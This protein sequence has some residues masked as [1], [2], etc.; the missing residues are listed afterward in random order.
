[1]GLISVF[2][3]KLAVL[4]Q[5]QKYPLLQA[6]AGPESA[7]YAELARQIAGGN[8]G[9]GPGL[10]FFPPLYPYFLAFVLKMAGSYFWT[11]IVQISLGTAAIALI[12]R[13]ADGW[14]G[15][16]AA[17]LAAALA[18]FTG[19]FTFY[20]VLL[21]PSAL[22]PFLTALTLYL[23][24]SALR[25]SESAHRAAPAAFTGI[26]F[27]AF[28]LNRPIVLLAAAGL[29]VVLLAARR[30]RTAVLLTAG[31]LVAMTPF[32]ARNYRVARDLSPVSSHGGLSFF[33]G[34]NADSDGTHRTADGTAPS[35]LAVRDDARQVAELAIGRALDDSEVSAHF[36]GLGW[37]WILSQPV[38][39]VR[40]F[41][42]KLAYVFNQSPSTV[43]YSLV[44]Y[45]RDEHN[46][47]RYLPVGAWLLV[48]AGIVGLWIAAPGDPPR[49]KTF[50]LWASFVPL[51]AIAVAIFYVSS[52]L[53]LPLLVPLCMG[54]GGALDAAATSWRSRAQVTSRDDDSGDAE[55]RPRIAARTYVAAGL[56]L[57]LAVLANWPFA[58]DDGRIE[59]RTRVAL[60][61]IGQER[62]DEAE[63][64]VTAIEAGH[65]RPGVLHFRIGR[66]MI[67]KEQSEAA[68]RHLERAQTL[69]PQPETDFALGQAL[70][71]AKRPQEAIP[72]LRR[73]YEAR[74]RPDLSGF[75]LARAHAAAGDRASAVRVLQTVRPERADD[76][77]SWR[78]LS[79][80]AME[81][82]APRLAEAFLR[83]A[84][85]VEPRSVENHEQLGL[86]L[87]LS[88]KFD[89]A[90]TAF[91]VAVRL[92]G[93]DVSARLNLAVSLAEIGR[94]DEARQHAEEALRIDPSYDKARQF[95]AAMAQKR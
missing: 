86:A 59:E 39:A 44:Y 67:A 5:F 50:W 64:R 56:L 24:A 73:A 89:E 68:V 4:L 22:D 31:V 65:P 40:L 84:L 18:T 46:I 52:R 53:R 34:N 2:A 79:Q 14:Y 33:I 29:A 82:Q 85:R 28:A 12:F 30:W 54:A 93:R 63:S 17:W 27:G 69:N 75:D 77:E 60:W 45:L 23:L 88:G 51:Y 36:Y 58:L 83:Q 72:H 32:L 80:L 70:M 81:V 43:G 15:R 13:I 49:R 47:L 19:A 6:S 35:I 10:Y 78:A 38:A 8:L 42:H 87:A 92:D 41:A 55:R 61:L 66:A 21:L 94:T 91:E 26:A 11:Q 74:V 48:P 76:A 95:L 16:R 90:V 37:R 1:V 62:Y 9:L 3:L 20:E 7:V 57:G 25:T 71:A